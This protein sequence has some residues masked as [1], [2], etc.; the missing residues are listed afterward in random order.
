MANYP[1]GETVD[2]ENSNNSPTS[3]ATNGKID[4]KS[5]W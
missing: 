4:L 2:R 1:M 5:K 3:T